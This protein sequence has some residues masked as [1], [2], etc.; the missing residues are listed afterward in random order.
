V[1]EDD[2]TTAY[3]A[4]RGNRA[5][6]PAGEIWVIDGYETSARRLHGPV[7]KLPVPVIVAGADW[8]DA[9]ACD[10]VLADAGWTRI[11]DWSQVTGDALWGANVRRSR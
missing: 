6:Q 7:L 11:D 10:A 8:I 3:A 4:G 2:I 5:S 1:I 9:E